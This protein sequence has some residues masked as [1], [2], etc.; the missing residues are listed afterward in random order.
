MIRNNDRA[1]VRKWHPDIFRL[2]A[3]IAAGEV[4]ITEHP[5]HRITVHG[6]GRVRGF[7]RVGIVT[8]TELLLL[9][10]EALAASNRERDDHALAFLQRAFWTGFD[11]LTHEFMAEDVAGTHARDVTVIEMEVGAADRGRSD[12]QDA[13]VR[14]D[15]FGVGNTFDADVVTA[16]PGECAHVQLLRLAAAL[17]GCRAPRGRRWSRPRR[18][19]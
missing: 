6:L 15:D 5:G 10:E 18:F 11:H 12:L 16:V 17:R 1:D 3:G 9:A 4:R 13:I 2:P 7:G 8:A 19:P 14:I